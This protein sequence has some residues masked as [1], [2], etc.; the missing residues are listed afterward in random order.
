MKA[1]KI[2]VLETSA[3]VTKIKLWLFSKI[4]TKRWIEKYFPWFSGTRGFTVEG[5]LE[6]DFD[7]P[8]DVLS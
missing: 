3:D 6:R 8:S 4:S 7:F 2:Q 5:F 1:S